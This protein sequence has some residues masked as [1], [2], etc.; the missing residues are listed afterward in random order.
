L[1]PEEGTFFLII[2]FKESYPE[3]AGIILQLAGNDLAGMF[4][5]KHIS[6]AELIKRIK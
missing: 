4:P 6:G 1:I 3:N 2:T 5:A